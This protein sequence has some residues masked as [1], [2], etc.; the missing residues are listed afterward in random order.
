MELGWVEKAFLWSRGQAVITQLGFHQLFDWQIRKVKTGN[1]KDI[2]LCNLYA[3]RNNTVGSCNGAALETVHPKLRSFSYKEYG[4]ACFDFVLLLLLPLLCLSELK[5]RHF[6]TPH[7]ILP[8]LLFPC[9]S[10]DLW[11]TLNCGCSNTKLG[12]CNR[13]WKRA[14]G[15]R[16]LRWQL[17]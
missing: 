14:W 12:A 7:H 3:I 5:P 13:H 4:K 9:S 6:P 10:R 8:T 1:L 11:K 15:E 2:M 17:I 16:R